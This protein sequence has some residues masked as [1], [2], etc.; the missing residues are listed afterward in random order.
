MDIGQVIHQ[1][2]LAVFLRTNAWA[3]PTLE[4]LHLIAIALL[5]GSIVVVDAR[6]LGLTR[7]LP[8]RELARHAL[9]WSLL[10]FAGAAATGSLLFVAHAADLIGNRVFIAKLGLISLAGANAALFHTGPYVSVAAWDVGVAP[11][12][13]ARAMALASI[14]IWIAVVVC[15]RWIAYA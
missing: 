6:I 11:P 2:P 13:G 9:P 4:S 5:F 10:A 3:Y 12:P 14:M 1:L 8:L 15:G 7:S